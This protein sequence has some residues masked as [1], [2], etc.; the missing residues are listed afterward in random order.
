MTGIL[1]LALALLYF[2]RPQGQF[3]FPRCTFHEATGLL[4]PGCGSLRAVHALL[5]GRILEAL[6]CNL[7][8]VLGTPLALGLW[9]GARWRG[10]P[11]PL[12]SK[13]VWVL[14]GIAALFTLARNLP[15]MPFRWLGP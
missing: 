14:F 12:G 9:I 15:G 13:L 11:V 1:G 3:F 2:H 5:H 8:L 10:V 6:Q 7:L 4:C